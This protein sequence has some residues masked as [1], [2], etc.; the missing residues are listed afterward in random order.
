MA[1][2]EPDDLGTTAIRKVSL[3]LRDE[4]SAGAVYHSIDLLKN[5][6]PASVQRHL[7]VCYEWAR[8]GVVHQMAGG[9]ST[10]LETLEAAYAFARDELRVA[11][12]EGEPK[13]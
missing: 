5:L 3:D 4:G 2:D 7:A 6:L 11:A 1:A 10:D 12:R 9:R 8:Q 13:E